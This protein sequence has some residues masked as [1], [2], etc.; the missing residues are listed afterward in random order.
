MKSTRYL[1]AVPAALALALTG[2]GGS[3]GNESTPAPSGDSTAAAGA[4]TDDSNCADEAVYCIGLVTD[5]GKVDDKSFNQSAYEGAQAAA[6]QL[7]GFQKYIETQDAKDY[8]ANIAQFTNKKYDAIVTVGFLMADATVAAAQANPGTRF[9]GVDQGYDPA[10]VTSKNITGLVFPEDQAG[11]GAGYLAGLMT[12]TNKL[13][14]VLGLEIPPVQKYAKGFEAGAKAAN[15]KVTVATVYHPAGDNAFNDP[16]W[17]AGEAKK[18]LAQGADLIF[19]AGGNTGNGAL[20]EIAKASGAGT[21]IFCIGVDTDQWDTVPAAQPCLI[22][23]AEKLIA[24]GVTDTLVTAKDGD[25]TELQTLGQAGLA[26]F[27]DFDSKIPE[28]IK[29]KVADIVKQM[30]AGT[31]K[32]GVT[33]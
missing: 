9:I 15:P 18:Q 29:T 23:S 22:T 5:T 4:P 6:K 24:K 27:H 14:Q 13:G 28:E 16:V 11:Y 1:V 17:G 32:T 26:P 33:L 19:G 2:C 25:F 12:K 31:L 20:Q 30:E 21:D 8:A 3:T 10:A 7:G